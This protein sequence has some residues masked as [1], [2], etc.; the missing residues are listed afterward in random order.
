MIIQLSL[1]IALKCD[2]VGQWKV[3]KTTVENQPQSFLG[4]PPLPLSKP[5]TDPVQIEKQ[6]EPPTRL[7]TTRPKEWH[8]RPKPKLI[9][10]PRTNTSQVSG[11]P[12]SLDQIGPDPA[13]GTSEKALVPLS[14]KPCVEI[15]APLPHMELDHQFASIERGDRHRTGC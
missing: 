8:V 10:R 14:S 6:I 9:W 12:I 3:L 1:N 5:T 15:M 13:Q 7:P 11:G 4:P 2:S